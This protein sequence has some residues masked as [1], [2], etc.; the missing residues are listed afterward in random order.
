M[1]SAFETAPRL[2]IVFSGHLADAPGRE[3]PRLSAD[4]IESATARIGAAIDAFRVG[5]GDLALTQGAAGSDLVFAELALDRGLR[6]RLLLPLP[7]EDFLA[8]SVRPVVDGERWCE[9]FEAVECR[10]EAAD[11]L[12]ADAVLGPLRADADPDDVFVRGNE[13]LLDAAAASG[14]PSTMLLCLWDGAR[15]GRGGTGEMVALATSR[16]LPVTRIDTGI[17]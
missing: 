10:V 14:A 17:L 7:R 5:P 15:G 6:L 3:T 4:R 13:W 1:P 12:E 11:R 9:R 8:R 16:G 2:A